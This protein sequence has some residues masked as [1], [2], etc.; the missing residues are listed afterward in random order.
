[1]QIEH[2]AI[3]TQ[4]LERLRA[5]YETFFKAKAGSKYINSAKG[6]E[7][8]F[9][10]FGSGPRLEVMT[11]A[12]LEEAGA[13]SLK[14]GYAHL[15]VSVGSREAVLALTERIEN[16]GYRVASPPRTTGDGYFESVVVDPDGNLVEITV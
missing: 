3:W 15:A 14:T 11:V 16:A 4:D 10:S 6:F 5:F 12:G 1:M 9:L 13:S 8:Y 2:I 7:S